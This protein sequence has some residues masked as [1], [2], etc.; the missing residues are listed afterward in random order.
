MELIHHLRLRDHVNRLIDLHH[1]EQVLGTPADA[2]FLSDLLVARA[3]LAN[4][5]EVD[6]S[7][8]HEV[9][10]QA[11]NEFPVWFAMVRK[12]HIRVAS[13]ELLAELCM[14]FARNFRD[15]VGIFL[16][17]GSASSKV[18]LH[19]GASTP[20]RR[21]GG[22][23]E[24]LPWQ[25]CSELGVITDHG[26]DGLLHCCNG[27]AEHGEGL[28]REQASICH[29]LTQVSGHPLSTKDLPQ[30]QIRRV[31]S[32]GVNGAIHHGAPRT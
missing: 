23:R 30:R 26:L 27:V 12:N 21:Q 11:L 6:R 25:I 5:I 32:I 3:H 10:L 22:Q 28:N 20:N 14:I 7:M 9:A 15:F 2:R 18:F 19:G 29:D 16:H 8:N 17:F 1:L 24:L 31:I 13:N 4:F